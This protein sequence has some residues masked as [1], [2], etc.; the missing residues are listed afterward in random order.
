MTFGI[1]LRTQIV[2]IQDD[3]RVWKM[4]D[5]LIHTQVWSLSFRANRHKPPARAC[6]LLLTI[7]IAKVNNEL[8]ANH[9]QK[10]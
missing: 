2:T 8:Q 4:V 5:S 3:F 1:P 10:N 7:G 9:M 6:K